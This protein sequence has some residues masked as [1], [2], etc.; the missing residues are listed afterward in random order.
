MFGC[1]WSG[2]PIL[3]FTI[4][5]SLIFAV[6]LGV[7]GRPVVVVPILKNY[8]PARGLR[9]MTPG[10]PSGPQEDPKR[11]SGR[12]SFALWRVARGPVSCS[13][14]DSVVDLVMLLVIALRVVW[15]RTDQRSVLGRLG[16]RLS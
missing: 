4:A 15:Q 16:Y 12:R 1:L 7:F 6:F 5:K 8:L 11:V 14:W 10:R 2:V 9:R 3:G 13:K